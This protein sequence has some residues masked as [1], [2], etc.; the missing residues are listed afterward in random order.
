[1]G[2]NRDTICDLQLQSPSFELMHHDNRIQ[3]RESNRINTRINTRIGVITE[4]L[5]LLLQHFTGSIYS[6]ELR[7]NT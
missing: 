7:D 4:T 3:A 1:M 5:V 2:V 6:I